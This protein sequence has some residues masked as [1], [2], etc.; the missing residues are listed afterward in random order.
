MQQGCQE[1]V[2][3]SEAMKTLG[4]P[5][6]TFFRRLKQAGVIVFTNGQDR[7]QRYVDRRDLPRLMERPT[8]MKRSAGRAA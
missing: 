7:R 3:Y 5:R 1:L 4:L 2:E 6:R 8:G